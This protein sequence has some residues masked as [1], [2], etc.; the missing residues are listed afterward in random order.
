M[1]SFYQD[2]LGTNIGKTQK[3]WRLSQV[4]RTMPEDVASELQK[5]TTGE[6]NATLFE[7]SLCLSRA[8]LG[9]MTHFVYK[10]HKKCRFSH[11]R[12]GEAAQT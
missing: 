3:E 12:L 1:R 6:K 2:R 10:W 8:C 4:L 7:F 11:Q 9:K 5:S